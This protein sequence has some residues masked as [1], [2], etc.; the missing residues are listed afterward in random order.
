MAQQG[1]DHLRSSDTTH[2][3]V[4]SHRGDWRGAPE[5]S[6]QAIRNCIDMEV[7]MVEIDLKMTKDNHL[8]LMH[9]KTIDR[10]TN[11]SG[12]PSDYTLEE[13]R[14]FRL[15]NGTGRATPHQIPT[16]REVLQLTRGKILINI[17][18]GYDYF[19]EVYALLEETGTVDQVIIKSSYPYERVLPRFRKLNWGEKKR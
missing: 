11:G 10:T 5:N 6:L 17:D 4:V 15:T 9:D 1:A 2:V 16:L 7:D 12:K 18:K 19:K 13:I 8:I 3:F 14:K